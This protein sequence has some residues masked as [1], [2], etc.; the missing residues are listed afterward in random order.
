[1][2]KFLDRLNSCNKKEAFYWFHFILFF[3][4]NLDVIFVNYVRGAIL[5]MYIFGYAFL[6]IKHPKFKR[7]P[8][9]TLLIFGVFIILKLLFMRNLNVHIIYLVITVLIIKEFKYEQE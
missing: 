6:V 9:Y 2:K 1:M 7:Q 4:S 8:T 3:T 5:G